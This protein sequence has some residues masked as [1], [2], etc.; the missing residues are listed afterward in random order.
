MANLQLRSSDALV[1]GVDL[2]VKLD[3]A[4]SIGSGYFIHSGP[5]GF[6]YI[7]DSKGNA[8]SETFH[9]IEVF[10]SGDCVLLVG[11]NGAATHLLTPPKNLGDNFVRSDVHAHG[12][13]FDIELNLLFGHIGAPIFIIDFLTGKKVSKDFL[14][15]KRENGKIYGKDGFGE[16]GEWEEIKLDNLDYLKDG[17]ATAVKSVGSLEFSRPTG[18]L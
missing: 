12:F 16:S 4:E 13:Y 2:K 17:V 7:A 1:Q 8:L 6:K 3:K 11:S 10:R 9:N 14:E 15:I 5:G 18:K